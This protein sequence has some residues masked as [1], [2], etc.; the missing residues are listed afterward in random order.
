M[1]RRIFSEEHNIFREA[2]RKF[3]EKEVVPYHEQWEKDGI[4]PREVYKK[5]G[6][7]GFLCPWLPEELGGVEAD[8]LYS[9]IEIEECAYAHNSGFLMNLHSDVVAPY[10]YSF[11]TEEQKKQWLPDCASGDKILAVAMT[12]PNAGSDLA[13]MKTTAVKDGNE[14]VINGA[15]TFISNG[16]CSDIIV[17]AV[18]TDPKSD[19]PQAGVSLIV[20]EAD[21]PGFIRG[22]KLEKMGMHAQDTAEMMFEDCR[23]PAE[24][25]LGVEGGG[26]MYLMQKLQQERLVTAVAAEASAEAVLDLTIKYCQEREQFGRPLTKFQYNRFKLAEMKTEVEIGRIFMDRL[27]EEHAKGEHI[28]METCMAKWWTTDMLKRLADQGVQLHGG[29][30]YMM[31]YQI[32]KAFIDSRVQ[33]IFAGTNEIMKELIGRQMGL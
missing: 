16:I 12:E 7:Q 15:K 11:G 22:R 4:V 27:I 3:L 10:I 14:Y 33:T 29:Y 24:N 20:V 26:F 21:T 18:K 19:P 5:A 13:G 9:A 6:D 2:F 17:L 28:L 23:V 1:K 30:G 31:E 25:L 32:C 8:F